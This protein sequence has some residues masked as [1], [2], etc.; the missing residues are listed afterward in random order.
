MPSAAALAKRQM[1]CTHTHTSP[2]PPTYTHTHSSTHACKSFCWRQLLPPFYFNIFILFPRRFCKHLWPPSPPCA[3]TPSWRCCRL[4]NF[5]F[6]F[7]SH[8]HTQPHAAECERINFYIFF[9]PLKII[10]ERPP[11][12]FSLSFF[13]D[14]PLLTFCCAN[15]KRNSNVY[16]TVCACVCVAAYTHTHIKTHAGKAHLPWLCL[17]FVVAANKRKA[18][19][20]TRR[21]NH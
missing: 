5:Y 21:D 7:S 14:D 11:S 8:T 2:L 3:A 10:F 18:H 16:L 20:A 17:R 4:F 6:S 9:L 15:L 1:P 12:P 13:L 19:R